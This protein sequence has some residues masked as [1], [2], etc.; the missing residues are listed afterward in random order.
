MKNNSPVKIDKWIKILIAL[1]KFKRV[2]L[3]TISRIT[4]TTYSWAHNI[5]LDFER[6]G[7][8]ELNKKGRTLVW[9]FTEKGKNIVTCCK[10]LNTLINI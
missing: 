5:I 7:W 9:K 3:Y 4:N 10:K 1:D 6:K 2:P 8:I